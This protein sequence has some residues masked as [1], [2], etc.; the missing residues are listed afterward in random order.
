MCLLGG[1]G[2]LLSRMMGEVSSE[3]T[4]VHSC[5][6]RKSSIGIS[7]HGMGA[8]IPGGRCWSGKP[9]VESVVTVGAVLGAS[10]LR[11]GL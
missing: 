8:T 11:S 4:S 3:R 7:R 9:S 1:V 5:S 6:L 2:G 10:I